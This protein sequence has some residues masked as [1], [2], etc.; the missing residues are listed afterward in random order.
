MRGCAS[1]DHFEILRTCLGMHAL[2]IELD[3]LSIAAVM[4]LSGGA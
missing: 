2:P 4:M 3:D 1:E